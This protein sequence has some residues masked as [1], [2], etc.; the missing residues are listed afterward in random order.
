MTR[1]TTFGL[2][3]RVIGVLIA[4]GI[5]VFPLYW[6]LVTA[7]S[8]NADLFASSP[9]LIPDPGQIGVFGTALADGKAVGWLVNSL[10]IATG[11]MIVSI[12]LGIPLGYALSR[13]SFRGKVIVT[14]VLLFT[15]MLPV[16]CAYSSAMR[17][18]DRRMSRPR[19]RRS[20][21]IGT[22]SS[23]E[24]TRAKPRPIR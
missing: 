13:F 16:P 21:S 14:I 24:I 1:A 20:W 2:V 10:I 9:R 19:P 7:L 8:S 11:T 15:Q 22:S 23:S 3:L 18:A 12:G 17:G 6:M 4:L 5:A